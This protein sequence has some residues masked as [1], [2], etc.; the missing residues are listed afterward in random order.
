MARPFP[1][2][3]SE[4]FANA[5]GQKC[6]GRSVF[7]VDVTFQLSKERGLVIEADRAWLNG[8]GGLV[9][10]QK[11]LTRS[12]IFPS[13]VCGFSRCYAILDNASLCRAAMDGDAKSQRKSWEFLGLPIRAIRT[14]RGLIKSEVSGEWPLSPLTFQGN[15]LLVLSSLIHTEASHQ[16][17]KLL[18]AIIE[19]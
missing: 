6:A 17:S 11:E 2:L 14:S 15:R 1:H 19:S 16:S 4:L 13:G 18:M 8:S 5:H 12:A 10:S 7:F 9:S 3:S